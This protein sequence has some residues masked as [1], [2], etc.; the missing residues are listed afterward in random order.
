MKEEWWE[1][2]MREF[3]PYCLHWV[4]SSKYQV[5]AYNTYLSNYRPFV[6]LRITP[7][8]NGGWRASVFDKKDWQTVDVDNIN[9]IELVKLKCLI[10]AKKYDWRVGLTIKENKRP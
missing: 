10:Q 8:P 6:A 3:V 5:I 7:N 2:K 9:D 4:G 1:K